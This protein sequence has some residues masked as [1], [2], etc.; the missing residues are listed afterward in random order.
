M[1]NLVKNISKKAVIGSKRTFRTATLA[2][3]AIAL[4]IFLFGKSLLSCCAC[5]VH[6]D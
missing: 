3:T 1:I 5:R 6:G 4:N 2:T